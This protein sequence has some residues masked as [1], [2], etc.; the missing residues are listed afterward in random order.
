MRLSR[1]RGG[2]VS[3]ERLD[4]ARE[5]TWA[6][7]RCGTQARKENTSAD[8]RRAGAACST[9]IAAPG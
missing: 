8:N 3:P 7:D 5:P 2:A 9:M 1:G 6:A 4:G